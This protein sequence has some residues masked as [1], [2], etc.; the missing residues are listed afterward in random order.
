MGKSEHKDKKRKGNP[1]ADPADVGAI[2][3]RAAPRPPAPPPPRPRARPGGAELE[4]GLPPQGCLP[5]RRPGGLGALCFG[6][7]AK[8]FLPFP[9]PPQLPVGGGQ[10]RAE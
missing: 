1:P 7:G 9:S 10:G 8:P 4:A 5:L 2:Q 3:V 6:G